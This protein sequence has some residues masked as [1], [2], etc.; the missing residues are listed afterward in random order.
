MTLPMCNCTYGMSLD[1]ESADQV[2]LL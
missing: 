1:V 2:Q